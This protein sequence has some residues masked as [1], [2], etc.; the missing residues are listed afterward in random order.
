M[1]GM[2]AAYL[3]V[4]FGDLLVRGALGG[5]FAPTLEALMFWIEMRLFVAP[6]VLLAQ[7]RRRAQPGQAVRRGGAADAGRLP[8][9]PQRLPDRLRHRR[10]A[11]SYF[12]SV[13]EIL[14]TVGMIAVEVLGYIVL[15]RYAAGAAE[16]RS[17]RI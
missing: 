11:G 13:P 1:L 12:P 17:R 16:A 10:R 15:V 9:A 4:R 2:L 8:A 7:A 5:A 3:V 6:L 14:V